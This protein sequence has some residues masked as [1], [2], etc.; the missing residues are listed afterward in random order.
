[1]ADEVKVEDRVDG[2]EELWARS[3]GFKGVRGESE[4]WQRRS[5][6]REDVCECP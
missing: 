1:M 6:G 4:D 5:S 3:E 2:R